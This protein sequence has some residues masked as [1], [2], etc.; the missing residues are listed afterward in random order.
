LGTCSHHRVPWL[1]LGIGLAALAFFTWLSLRDDGGGAPNAATSRAVSAAAPTAL[2]GP[3]PGRAGWKL[4]WHDEFNDPICPGPSKWSFEYGF[5][6]NEE[7]QWYQPENASCH[8]GV[9]VIE[10]RREEVANPFHDP[11]VQDWRQSWEGAAYTSA[12]MVSRRAFTYGRFEI[13][14]R[15]DTRRGSW[16]AFWTLG[17][18][19]KWPQGG[20]I[21]VMEYYRNTVLANVC[22]PR[23][24]G[25]GWSSAR[26]SLRSLGGEAWA[27]RPHLWAM[28]WNAHEIDLFLDG[29][30]VNHLPVTR[31][32]RAGRPNPY[33]DSPHQLLLSQAI[34]G[35]NGGDPAYTE[36]PVRL[37]VDYV[38]VYKRAG[39]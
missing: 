12:S 8:D 21:D 34:G 16:P 22:K 11:G 10:A 7:L 3:R 17:A 23:P 27:D 26:Q 33:I 1:L 35:V 20:E 32:V 9:L 5:V 37:E 6:R 39:R 36:F 2:G 24:W 29:E 31:A 4:I 25:C 28:E 18:E 15:I 38:R 14:A 30:L 19:G 13:W